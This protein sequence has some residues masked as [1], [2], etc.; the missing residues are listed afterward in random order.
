MAEAF[1]REEKQAVI[2]LVQY[3][4]SLVPQLPTT[5]PIE[6]VWHALTATQRR[7]ISK[8]LDEIDVME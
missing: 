1:S 3:V 4:R 7:R 8:R 5:A 2:D 6:Q